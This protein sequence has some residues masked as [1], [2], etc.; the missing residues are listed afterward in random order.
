MWESGLAS[1][2]PRPLPTFCPGVGAVAAWE[3]EQGD[4]DAPGKLARA[5]GRPIRRQRAEGE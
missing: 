2:G 4:Q 5:A 3:G 1:G